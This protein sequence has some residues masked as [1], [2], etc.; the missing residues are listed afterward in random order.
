VRQL[1]TAESADTKSSYQVMQNKFDGALLG[2]DENRNQASQEL[3]KDIERSAYI[4]EAF[5][6]ILDQLSFTKK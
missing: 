5:Q 6:I 4:E 2:L 3:L 1:E